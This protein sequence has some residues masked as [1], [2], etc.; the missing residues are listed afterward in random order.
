LAP[1]VWDTSSGVA[2]ITYDGVADLRENKLVVTPQNQQKDAKNNACI[3]RPTMMQYVKNPV[4]NG[5]LNRKHD[6]GLI[7]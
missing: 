1:S 7:N 5:F 2:R 4:D 3:I 6:I